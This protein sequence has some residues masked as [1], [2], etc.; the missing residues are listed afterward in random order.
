[1]AERAPAILVLAPSGYGKTTFLGQLGARLAHA[2]RAEEVVTVPPEATGEWLAPMLAALALSDPPLIAVDAAETMTDAALRDLLLLA[3][4][5]A[6]A[7]RPAS[8]VLAGEPDL[9]R[10]VERLLPVR[11]ARG[12]PK[13][14]LPPWSQDDVLA[15]LRARAA[16]TGGELVHV[17][18]GAAARLVEIT[19]GRPDTICHLVGGGSQQDAGAGETLPPWEARPADGRLMRPL[20][21]VA[22]AR[23]RSIDGGTNGDK[24]RDELTVGDE[25]PPGLSDGVYPPPVAPPSLTGTTVGVLGIGRGIGGAPRSKSTASRVGRLV[26]M[27]LV[28]LSIVAAGWALWSERLP[29]GGGHTRGPHMAATLSPKD[30]LKE[31]AARTADLEAAESTAAAVEPASPPAPPARASTGGAAPETAGAPSVEASSPPPVAASASP[32][33][34]PTPAAAVPAPAD[35]VPATEGPPAGEIAE[36]IGR[37]DALLHLADLSAARQ[38]YLLAARRGA[39]AGLTAAAGTYDPVYLRSVGVPAGAGNPQRAIELYREAVGKGEQAAASR[40]RALVN[41]QREAGAIDAVEA[42]RLSEP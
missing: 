11:Q 13:T 20:S 30:P 33:P 16:A 29:E 18:S 6:L 1:M 26:P 41:A 39:A 3:T 19:K 28:V 9:A 2:G 24:P 37:G 10:R 8:V 40:L 12:L 25:S 14:T 17:D 23:L 31:P 22:A 5:P 34:Q 7:G 27:V 36:L 38:F 21:A 4:T 42:R 32:E 15:Y 35:P